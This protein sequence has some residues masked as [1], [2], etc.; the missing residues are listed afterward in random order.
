MPV[1]EGRT[2]AP[3]PLAD[4]CL[5]ELGGIEPYTN[6]PQRSEVRSE[7]VAGVR[8]EHRY[9]AGAAGWLR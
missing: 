6:F 1:P 8:Q 7:P 3:A 2:V 9:F 4:G 5:V